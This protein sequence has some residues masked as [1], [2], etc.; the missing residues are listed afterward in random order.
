[1]ASRIRGASPLF[2]ELTLEIHR[3]DRRDRIERDFGRRDRELADRILVEQHI[4]RGETLRT[5]ER[6]RAGH[7]APSPTWRAF[8]KTPR[9][10]TV[11][12]RPHQQVQVDAIVAAGRAVHRTA[13][14]P[15]R[16]GC[17]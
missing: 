13:T 16:A 4:D 11:L 12:V 10:A 8:T 6:T 2:T 15:A 3:D 7:R 1:M 9:T 5:Y 14:A 17:R